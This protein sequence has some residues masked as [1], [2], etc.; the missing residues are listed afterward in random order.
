MRPM[1][2]GSG[3]VALPASTCIWCSPEQCLPGNLVGKMG[4]SKSAW[5]LQ[6][7]LQAIAHHERK[8]QQHIADHIR[9]HIPA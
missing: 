9:Q 7:L 4:Y 2:R 1:T 8:S 5:L 3:C 6:F